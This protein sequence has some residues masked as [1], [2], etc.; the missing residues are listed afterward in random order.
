M[1]SG[2]TMPE[3]NDIGS[4]MGKLIELVKEI[5]YQTHILS[6]AKV[7]QLTSSIDKEPANT[8]N[9]AVSAVEIVAQTE[10]VN[11]LAYELIVLTE[12]RRQDL[13]I[14]TNVTDAAGLMKMREQQLAEQVQPR[15]ASIS[16]E[17]ASIAKWGRDYLCVPL[18]SIDLLE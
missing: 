8:E 6:H 10:L 17:A 1:E 12:G 14:E 18:D 2:L 9:S 5:A 11:R 13:D 7:A 16:T 4:E 15:I 3:I